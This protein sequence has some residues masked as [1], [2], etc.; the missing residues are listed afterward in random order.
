MDSF[1]GWLANSSIVR[2]AV[3][4]LEEHLP[5]LRAWHRFEYERH[6]AETKTNARMFAGV[7]DSFSIAHRA[8]LAR[9]RTGHDH[10][11]LAER[12]AAG[13]WP[14]DYPVV[15]WLSK[16]L[17]GGPRIF[18][19]GGATGSLFYKYQHYLSY[20]AQMVWNV[21]DVESVAMRGRE[22]AER[23]GAI[24]L[25]FTSKS[26]EAEGAD[27]LLASGSLQF[28]EIPIWDLLARLTHKPRHLLINRVP[29]WNGENFVTLHNFGGA[30]CAYQIWN[31]DQFEKGLSQVKYTVRDLWEAAEFSCSVPFHTRHRVKTYKG[32]YCTLAP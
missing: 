27:I 19:L 12:H 5:P 17:A 18:D 24:G 14:S 30:F 21:C 22:V 1:E 8:A 26:E 13:M 32:M 9:G 7:Y 10:D 28:I 20:P 11:E 31:Q 29:L 6:F 4:F 2:K 25:H 3:D 15:F 16:L 23:N